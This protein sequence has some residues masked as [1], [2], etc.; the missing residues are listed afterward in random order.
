MLIKFVKVLEMEKIYQTYSIIMAGL[1]LRKIKMF[2]KM[3]NFGFSKEKEKSKDLLVI[4]ILLH[5]FLNLALL[6]LNLSISLKMGTNSNF[7]KIS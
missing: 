1:M 4:N 5:G 6:G 7:I 3:M 2:K